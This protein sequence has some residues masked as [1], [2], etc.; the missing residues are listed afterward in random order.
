[1]NETKI[2]VDANVIAKW[3]ISEA[4]PVINTYIT[5]LKSNDKGDMLLLPRNQYR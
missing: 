3:F 1:M 5:N 2:V 4:K